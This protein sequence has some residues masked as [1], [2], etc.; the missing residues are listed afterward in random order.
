MTHK[1]L[2]TILLLGVALSVWATAHALVQLEGP[3]PFPPYREAVEADRGALTYEEGAYLLFLPS[4]QAP[5]QWVDTTVREESL[6]LYQE[7]Y[8]ATDG[9]A[10]GWA[11]SHE[12]CDAGVTSEA[13]RAATLR[14]INY[15]RS[16]AGVPKIRALD[17]TY[18]SKAQAAALMMSV[19]SELDHTPDPDWKCFSEAG[20]EGAGS[21]NLAMG[22]GLDAIVAY[23]FDHGGGN[24]FV[25][26]RRWIL[27]PQTQM[28]GTGDV[29]SSGNYPASNALW[30]FDHEHIWDDHPATRE[31]FVAWPPPGY[32]P[33][34]VIFP[35]W[36]LSYPG[37]D[38]TMATV[39]MTHAGQ[40]IKVSVN[41]PLDGFGDNTLVWEP[42]MP[43]STPPPSEASYQ[44]SVKHV[45]IGGQIRSFDYTVTV[46]SP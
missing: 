29:P 25:G 16:M 35:R 40:A 41:P 31:E 12:A 26:H 14:R 45:V 1:L 28:M 37:A 27:Y 10:S 43:S 36:S 20:Y 19:N 42:Q 44:V 13:F 2:R 32:V 3:P 17:D 30:V 24:Y 39:T 34:P 4:V 21:S 11:G 46:F 22:T 23:M 15:F 18:N 8:L 33:D 38:F 7:E 9:V 6:R 5:H